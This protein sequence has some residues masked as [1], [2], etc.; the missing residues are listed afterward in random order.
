MAAVGFVGGCAWHSPSPRPFG[1]IDG[2]VRGEKRR[3][4]PGGIVNIVHTTSR[5][6]MVGISPLTS[7][8]GRFGPGNLPSGRCTGKADLAGYEP[9]TKTVTVV[10]GKSAK[11]EFILRKK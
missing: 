3:P 9:Q 10:E 5:E 6:E 11:V 4:L 1:R 7:E 8:G 2:A